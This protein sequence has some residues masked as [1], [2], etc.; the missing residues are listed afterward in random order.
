MAALPAHGRHV[1][2]VAV[3]AIQ[4]GLLLDEA[5]VLER[6]P[7][8]GVGAQEVIRAPVLAHGRHEGAPTAAKHTLAGANYAY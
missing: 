2:L 5:D 7:A 4:L 8:A 6:P 3:L 1:G